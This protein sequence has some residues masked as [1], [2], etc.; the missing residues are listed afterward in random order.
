MGTRVLSISA[1]EL[2]VR[3][4]ISQANELSIV[5]IRLVDML[6]ARLSGCHHPVGMRSHT[7]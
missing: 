1:V 3:D 2:C 6:R 5:R 7:S 4:Q